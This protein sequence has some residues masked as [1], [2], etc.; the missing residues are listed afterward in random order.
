M[1]GPDPAI[2]RGTVLEEMAG[3]GPAMTWGTAMTEGM[4]PAMM[5]EADIRS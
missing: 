1:A 5:G 2:C 3:S 4:V